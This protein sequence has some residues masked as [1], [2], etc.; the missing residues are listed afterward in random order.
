MKD[1]IDAEKQLEA[2]LQAKNLTAPRVIPEDLD[3]EIASVHYFTA[4]QG[5]RMEGLDYIDKLG[6]VCEPSPLKPQLGLLTFCVLV[7]KNGF[8]EHGSSACASPE[9][10]DENEGRTIAFK[11][12]REKLW[13]LLG[14]RLRDNLSRPQPVPV[15]IEETTAVPADG[16]Y[17]GRPVELGDQVRFFERV[18]TLESAPMVAT[19][20]AVLAENRV[21]LSVIAPN[22]TLHARESVVLLR[23][24]EI[25]PTDL[26]YYARQR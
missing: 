23:Y 16:T 14:F 19:V 25:P 2:R 12:A 1:M 21:G 17:A 22:G 20:S 8:M 11:N 4:L 9:N 5:A 7:L 26:A 10:F 15:L 3:N 24:G 18:N 13:P 6:Q